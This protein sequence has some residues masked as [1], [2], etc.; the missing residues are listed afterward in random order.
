LYDYIA[1]RF[2]PVLKIG[3]ASFGRVTLL[4]GSTTAAPLAAAPTN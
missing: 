1:F 4:A 2:M 3:E